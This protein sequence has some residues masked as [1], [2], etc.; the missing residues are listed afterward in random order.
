MRARFPASL[1][2]AYGLLLGT[3]GAGGS[4][5][6]ARDPGV[7]CAQTRPANV[8]ARALVRVWADP[9]QRSQAIKVITPIVGAEAW[10]PR[11]DELMKS[12]L[13]SLELLHMLQL[14]IPRGGQ[15]LAAARQRYRDERAA[16]QADHAANLIPGRPR[17][18]L[19]IGSGDG[20]IAEELARRWRLDPQHAW[21]LDLSPPPASPHVTSITYNGRGQIPLPPESIDAATLVMVLHHTKNPASVLRKAY[22]VLRPGGCLLIRDH[23]AGRA[24]DVRFLQALHQLLIAAYGDSPDYPPPRQLR[25]RAQW[26]SLATA[27]GFTVVKAVP[28]N[29]DNPF[30]SFTLVLQKSPRSGAASS[31]AE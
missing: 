19:D 30:V 10:V 31:S 18:F 22:Q 14:T 16:A 26:E 21:A 8:T 12:P 17:R 11:L 13:Q 24:A 1:L 25:S 6:A 23:D 3:A 28:P 2:V 27:E 15:D 29:P 4:S 9:V 20:A 7:S 5:Q